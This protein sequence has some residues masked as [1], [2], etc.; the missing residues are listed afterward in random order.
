VRWVLN[1]EDSSQPRKGRLVS[2]PWFVALSGGALMS[3]GE[4]VELLTSIYDSDEVESRSFLVGLGN[5]LL[6]TAVMASVVY[7]AVQWCRA[8]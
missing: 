7:W 6:F 5:G 8:F 1:N 4:Q 3:F 2:V